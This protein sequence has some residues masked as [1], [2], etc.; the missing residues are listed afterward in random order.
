M[1]DSGGV[2]EA[3]GEKIKNEDK[4]EKMKMWKEKLRKIT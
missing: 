2:G 4:G 1:L 3:A